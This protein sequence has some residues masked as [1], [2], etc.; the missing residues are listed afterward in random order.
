[1]PDLQ[2]LNNAKERILSTIRMRGPSLP[3]HIAKALNTSPLFASAFLSELYSDKELK[4][5]DMKVGNSP[6]YYIS[7]QEPSLERFIQHLNTREKEA[8]FI[9]KE[10][11]VLNDDKQTPVVRVALRAIKDFAIPVKIR[12]NDEVK[13]FWKYFQLSDEELK[14]R[15]QEIIGI[16]RK[17]EEPQAPA[18][19]E[20]VDK[21]ESKEIVNEEEIKTVPKKDD[22]VI[23]SKEDKK[24]EE[25]VEDDN[26]TDTESID[27]KA[28][29][30]EK[31]KPKKK[32]KPVDLKFTNKIKNYLQSKNI[33]LIE[34]LSEKK[35]E[36]IAKVKIIT[37]LGEQGYLLI[38]KDKKKINETDINL[39]IQKSQSEKM[40]ALIISTGELDKSSLSHLETW[41][42]LIK[43]EKL[44]H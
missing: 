35:K 6:L 2:R 44:H 28:I 31:T 11:K 27:D 23:K 24:A 18:P 7:G 4:M 1:M 9:L 34:S 19:K 13:L 25:E 8:F 16:P 5:S 41:K 30:Q 20:I 42:N 17:Q 37:H 14:N 43:F 12:L 36:F 39:A 38:S 33:E 15:L 22:K 32:T 21:E 3:V 26:V 10:S 40:P 29:P